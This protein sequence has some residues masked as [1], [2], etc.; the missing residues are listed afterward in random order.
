MSQQD[1]IQKIEKGYY[2]KNSKQ[3][4]FSEKLSPPKRDKFQKYHFS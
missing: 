3:F 1:L 4:E 2:S